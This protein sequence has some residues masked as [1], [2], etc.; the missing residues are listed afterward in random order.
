MPK[1][2]LAEDDKGVGYSGMPSYIYRLGWVIWGAGILANEGTAQRAQR[3][4]EGGRGG[5]RDVLKDTRRQILGI[6]IAD[7]MI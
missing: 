7:I 2:I 3:V 4:G 1:T 5:P 6:I